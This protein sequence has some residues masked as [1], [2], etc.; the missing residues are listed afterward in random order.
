MET[1]K[2]SFFRLIFYHTKPHPITP[3]YTFM[4]FFHGIL[5]AHC[6][7]PKYSTAH[8]EYIVMH[9]SIIAVRTAY[10]RVH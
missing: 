3:N 8:Q 2:Q 6:S 7:R 9:E 1:C 10:A 5:E 4:T